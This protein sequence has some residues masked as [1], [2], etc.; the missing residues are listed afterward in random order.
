MNLQSFEGVKGPTESRNIFRQI[1]GNYHMS[2]KQPKIREN[3]LTHLIKRV[4]LK[5]R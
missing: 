2:W 3:K 1:R 4:G 5:K